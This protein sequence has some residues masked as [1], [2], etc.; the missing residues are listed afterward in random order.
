M[1]KLERKL[2]PMTKHDTELPSV[3]VTKLTEEDVAQIA[4]RLEKDDYATIFESLQDWH[5]LRTLAF[6]RSQLVEPYLHLLDI[7]AFD[8]C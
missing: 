5:I 2:S 3:D 1:A 7:E 4:Q 8:E 6:Q